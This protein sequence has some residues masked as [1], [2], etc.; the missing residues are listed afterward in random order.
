MLDGEGTQNAGVVWLQLLQ[1][2]IAR[3]EREGLLHAFEILPGTEHLRRP[4]ADPLTTVKS[5]SRSAAGQQA[6]HPSELRPPHVLK[7]T[8]VYLMESIVPLDDVY[9]TIVYDFVFDR[10]RAVRQEMVIQDLNLRHCIEILEPIIRFHAY[11]G[12]RLCEEPMDHFDPVINRTNLLECLKRLLV[13]YEECVAIDYRD[14]LGSVML[15]HRPEME[16][17]YLIV[18]L[19]S[20]EAIVRAINLES[21]WRTDVV[22]LALKMS[23]AHW[24]GNYVRVC[25]DLP[26]LP[27]LLAC[28]ANQHLP[29]IRR[30]AFSV[31][32]TAFSNRVGS[33][34]T[35]QLQSLLLYDTEQQLL[36]DCQH[37]GISTDEKGIRF[38]KGT[39]NNKSPLISPRHAEITDDEL[40]HHELADLLL[41]LEPVEFKHNLQEDKKCT[42]R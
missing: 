29:A 14:E 39:F 12:Y 4:K 23:I 25:R 42:K 33:Y 9:W 40:R 24:S 19:G 11:A 21:K 35:S 7:E 10:L 31:M 32:S 16:A 20:P 1:F 3:R 36:R 37:Y 27:V 18:S 38:L 8:I 6:P 34:P 26:K 5:F 28:A 30:H 22:K 13:M 41:G 17:L 15:K 2:S